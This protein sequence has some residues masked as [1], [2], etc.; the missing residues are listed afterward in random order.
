[1]RVGFV[2][3]PQGL[4]PHG[5]AW[6][7]I[8]NALAGAKLDVLVANE[9]PFG[10]W[11]AG[12]PLFDRDLAQRSV[13]L[14]E[15]GLSALAALPVGGI[16]TSRPSWD[17]ERLCNEAVVIEGGAVRPVRRKRYLPA[18]PGWWETAWYQHGEDNFPTVVVQGLCVGILLC[19]EAMFNERARHYGR[20]GAQLIAIPRATGRP[21]PWRVAGQMAAIV[22]GS[23]VVSSNRVGAAPGGPTFGGEGFAY[24]PDGAPIAATSPAQPLAVI[25]LDPAAVARQQREYPCYVIDN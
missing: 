4:Q 3:W 11:I 7:T 22:S 20:A 13:D 17:G 24:A 10:D 25:E 23:Y 16:V 2:E 15:Q 21:A 1:M 14:H 12:A 9:L 5:D 6:A 18:E 19:T 8:A